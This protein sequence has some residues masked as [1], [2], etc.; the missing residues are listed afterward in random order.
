MIFAGGR[1]RD[2]E[3]ND[4]VDS[5]AEIRLPNGAWM[6]IP[7]PLADAPYHLKAVSVG[8]YAVFAGGGSSFLSTVGTNI[9]YAFDS[10]KFDPK[11]TGS[12]RL[13]AWRPIRIPVNLTDTAV[14]GAVVNKIAN[15]YMVGGRASA[16]AVR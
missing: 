1:R 5:A 14:A 10:T 3:N 12:R 6:D 11:A 13:D 2:K 9:I 7:F 15:I 4:N 16:N 8:K